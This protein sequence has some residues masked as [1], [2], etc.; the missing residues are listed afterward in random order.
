MH[1]SFLSEKTGLIISRLVVFICI[2]VVFIACNPSPQDLRIKEIEPA[3]IKEMAREIENLVNPE[4]DERLSIHLWAPD[5]LVYDPISIN[6][7]DQGRLYYSRTNRQKNSEFDIRGH[8]DWEIG[9]IRLQ[10]IE[11]KRA[12]LKEV[13]SPENS[14]KNKWL[15]DLNGDGSHDW[16]DM[17]LEKEHIYRLEDSDGDGLADREDGVA[18][19][20]GTA[21]QCAGDDR[22]RTVPPRGTAAAARGRPARRHRLL[23]QPAHPGDHRLGTRAP[24]S[25]SAGWSPRWGRTGR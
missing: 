22:L 3:R 10:S 19:V 5:S 8:Q 17:T 1:R 7:D 18:R 15:A 12:F 23:R 11:D 4:L 13:L 20:P 14:D 2:N 24:F 21:R 16:R 6:F 9:S 25:S